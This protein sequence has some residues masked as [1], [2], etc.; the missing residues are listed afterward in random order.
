VRCW[1]SLFPD[2]DLV[3][4][5]N[6]AAAK[7]RKFH[8]ANTFGWVQEGARLLPTRNYVAYTASM[9]KLKGAFENTV[10]A[11]LSE[12][13]QRLVQAKS[14]LAGMYK[15]SDYPFVEEL[16]S[17]FHFE[18]VVMPVPAGT[19]LTADVEEKDIERIRE[20]IERSVQQTFRDANF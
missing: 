20:E 7:A 3:A 19:M 17:R 2:D 1:K 11:F 8:Y 14:N 6:G 12:Y 18:T 13:R 15:A 4:A 9:S 5:V 16:R 10:E